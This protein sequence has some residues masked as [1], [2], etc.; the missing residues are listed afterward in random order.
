MI[1]PRCK[2]EK[3]IVTNSRDRVFFIRRRR[4]CLCCGFRYTT[5]ELLAK[6]R[7]AFKKLE[8]IAEM[9]YNGKRGTGNG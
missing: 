7:K 5:L 6:D 9:I 3:D 2:G 4:E 8:N 1:C